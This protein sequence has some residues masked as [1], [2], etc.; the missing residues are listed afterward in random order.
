MGG[1]VKGSEFSWPLQPAVP[2]G[3]ES[4]VAKVPNDKLADWL[5]RSGW[6]KRARGRAVQV[7]AAERGHPHVSSDTA[8]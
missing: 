7:K 5:E 2:I 6:S 4:T 1:V 8:R 3:R